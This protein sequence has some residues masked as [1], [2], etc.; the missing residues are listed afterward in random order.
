M[1]KFACTDNYVFC[2]WVYLLVSWEI[3]FQNYTPLSVGY[4]TSSNKIFCYD[5]WRGG[6]L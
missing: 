1:R 3:I 2:Y 4:G 6:D 5:F